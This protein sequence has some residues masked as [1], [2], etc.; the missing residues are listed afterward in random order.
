M[1]NTI[2]ELKSELIRLPPMSFVSRH[3]FDPVPFCFGGD[4]ERWV[5]WKHALSDLLDVD[6][7]DV[8]LTGSGA[9][10]FSLN[11]TKN[12][13]K[14]DIKSDID[15]GVV[16]EHY[17]NISWRHL[18]KES[19]SLG[20]ISRE[21]S[22]AIK[23][24]RKHF[25]FLGTIAA[26]RMLSILPFGKNWQAALDLMTEM[27]PTKGRDVKLRIYKDFDAL[28]QYQAKNIE[29][30]RNEKILSDLEYSQDGNEIPV[31]DG[32]PL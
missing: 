1:V 4:A 26:D 6:A 23:D 21:T 9:L 10:G 12:F 31:E 25:V 32:E 7:R 24:H 15:C 16:S 22:E 19:V 20:S 14:F 8:V 5:E 11:P 18:R 17:F 30:I 13:K 3:L 27:E 29:K 2:D 28:R